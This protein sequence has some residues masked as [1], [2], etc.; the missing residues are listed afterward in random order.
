M[1]GAPCSSRCQAVHR[2]AEPADRHSRHSH[3]L[4]RFAAQAITAITIAVDFGI[5]Q[6]GWGCLRGLL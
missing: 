4:C 6:V 5:T 1:R 2:P 3:T